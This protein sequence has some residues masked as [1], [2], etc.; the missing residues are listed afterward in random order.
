MRIK[1]LL[2]GSLVK[3]FNGEKERMAEVPDGCTAEEALRT[4][5]IDWTQIR[6]FGF[7][8][9]NSKRVMIHDALEEGDELKAYPKITGG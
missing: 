6:N 3:Y 4:V 9:V 7:V 1:I 8:A 2:R 5:G